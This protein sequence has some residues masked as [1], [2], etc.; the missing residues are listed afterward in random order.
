MEYIEFDARYSVDDGGI[1]SIDITAVLDSV[2]TQLSISL[3]DF[4]ISMKE[5]QLDE[6]LYYLKDHVIQYTPNNYKFGKYKPDVT[7]APRVVVKVKTF[8]LCVEDS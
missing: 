7:F 6:L 3:G 1:S 4:S 8:F 2:G 5:R